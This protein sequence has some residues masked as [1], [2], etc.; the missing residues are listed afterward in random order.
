MQRLVVHP[1]DHQDLTGVVLLGDRRKEPVLIALQARSDGRVKGREAGHDPSFCRRSP[2]LALAPQSSHAAGMPETPASHPDSR[3]LATRERL[4][5]ADLLDEV[6]PD[7][8]TL[9]EGWVTRDLVAHLLVREGH[10]AAAG[11]MLPPLAGWTARQQERTASAPYASLVERF[12]HGPPLI[13]P[14][15]LPGAETAAN[16]FEHFVHHEDVRRASQIWTARELADDDQQTLWQHLTRRVRVYV[17]KPPVPVRLAAPDLGA[18]SVGNT[19]DPAAITLTGAPA[20]LV[21]YVHGRRDQAEVDV[22][23]P[24]RSVDQWQRHTL[25]V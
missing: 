25:G 20:E 11:I 5:L 24:E 14:L 21:L 19:D 1:P 18:I 12:R 23:G 10:P 17:R 4:A 9:C 3:P 22:D 13:S 15:R 8:P 2:Q 7:A 16:T 6:G